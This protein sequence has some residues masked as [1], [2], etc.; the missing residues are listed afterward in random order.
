[1][2][3]TQLGAFRP[4]LRLTCLDTLL[5]AEETKALAEATFL[6][7]Q[8]YYNMR[9][10]TLRRNARQIIKLAAEGRQVRGGCDPCP[11]QGPWS[12]GC[13]AAVLPYCGCQRDRVSNATTLS[14][15]TWHFPSSLT[16]R[17]TQRQDMHIVAPNALS[18]RQEMR[19]LPVAYCCLG[20]GPRCAAPAAQEHTRVGGKG[21]RTHNGGRTQAQ[22]RSRGRGRQRGGRGRGGQ[23][24]GERRRGGGR[25]SGQRGRGGRGPW[26][27]A[28]GV[29]ACAAG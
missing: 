24:P 12:L 7:K 5:L 23:R 21:R 16:D 17:F 9:I 20:V 15:A 26:E 8:M 28:G 13:L 22:Q 3:R 6:K 4:F 29:G 1:M 2:Q 25:Q 14:M 10:K 18:Y 27:G 11:R 19:L